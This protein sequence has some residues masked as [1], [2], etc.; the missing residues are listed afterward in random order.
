M[1][2]DK[3]MAGPWVEHAPGLRRRDYATTPGDMAASARRDGWWSAWRPLDGDNE[4]LL[5][6]G[7]AADQAAGMACADAALRAAGHLPLEVAPEAPG[8]RSARLRAMAEARGWRLARG[9]GPREMAW[10]GDRGWVAWDV[11]SAPGCFV[12]I[13]P[14]GSTLDDALAVALGAD[15]PALDR[16]E[17]ERVVI[18]PALRSRAEALGWRPGDDPGLVVWAVAE[19]AEAREEARDAREESEGRLGIIAELTAMN[20]AQERVLRDVA[21]ALGVA[22]SS[23][24]GFAA[25][26]RR[27]TAERDEARALL[28]RVAVALRLRD[29]TVQTWADAVADVEAVGPDVRALLGGRGRLADYEADVERLT[30]ERDG[31]R[32]ALEAT[33][34]ALH[35]IETADV[36][37]IAVVASRVVAERD[38]ARTEAGSLRTI[39]E[40]RTR[41]L[42]EVR[43][44]LRRVR[45][46]RDEA[47]AWAQVA[48]DA[49]TQVATLDDARTLLAA[50]ADAARALGEVAGIVGEPFDD[51][52]NV[53]LSVRRVVAD[54]YQVRVERDRL[55]AQLRA[56]E[57]LASITRERDDARTALAEVLRALGVGRG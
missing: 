13:L 5:C 12:A 57:D 27:L 43:A 56:Q 10:T 38:V 6:E 25:H 30:R 41:R 49:T 15:V 3:V 55:R 52:A 42:D 16:P 26:V 22:G 20:G 2:D 45:V 48:R 31:L 14:D 4:P 40:T 50:R 47:E 11:A 36:D 19:V 51:P 18:T 28:T 53:V 21:E 39:V 54:A 34:K 8:D 33:R 35:V 1:A 23:I 29:G 32:H 44:D 24:D 37:H 7:Q 9:H 17:A 46:T